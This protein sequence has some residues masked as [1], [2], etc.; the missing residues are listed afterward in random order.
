MKN[1]NQ[2]PVNQ[3]MPVDEETS[4]NKKWVLLLVALSCCMAMGILVFEKFL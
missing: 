1:P 3:A 4:A 2:T